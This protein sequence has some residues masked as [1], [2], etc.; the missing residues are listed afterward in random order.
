MKKADAE[1]RS[2]PDLLEEQPNSALSGR[3]LEEIAAT[4][5]TLEGEACFH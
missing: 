1:A 5:P 4:G 2:S 3:S